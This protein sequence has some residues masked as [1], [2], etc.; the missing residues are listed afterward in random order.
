MVE[1]NNTTTHKINIKGYEKT[2]NNILDVLNL[3]NKVSNLRNQIFC[4][5]I[6]IFS[7]KKMI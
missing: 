5:E 2:F 1:I 7:R 4:K 6:P 3:Y